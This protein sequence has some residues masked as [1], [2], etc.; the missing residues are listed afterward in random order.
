[1]QS[2]HIHNIK[3]GM[4]SVPV[5]FSAC[6][7]K[8]KVT[9]SFAMWARHCNTS[10]LSRNVCQLMYNV[11]WRRCETLRTFIAFQGN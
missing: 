11:I 4:Q 7:W 6:W 1:M 10:T 9:K 8:K 2:R 5:Q 3:T